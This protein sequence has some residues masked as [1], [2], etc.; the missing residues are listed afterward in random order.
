M[1]TVKKRT[2]GDEKSHKQKKRQREK[3]NSMETASLP[4][5]AIS[6]K[7]QRLC[8][9]CHR[10]TVWVKGFVQTLFLTESGS[11]RTVHQ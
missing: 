6:N 8:A 3:Q 11:L 10:S 9:Y 5:L 2:I 4:Y 1:G 7:Y